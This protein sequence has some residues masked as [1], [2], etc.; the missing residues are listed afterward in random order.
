[1]VRLPAGRS[2]SGRAVAPDGRVARIR[3]H[4]HDGD[5]AGD[6]RLRGRK[7]VEFVVHAWRVPGLGAEVL[8]HRPV[9]PGGRVAAWQDQPLPLEV[10]EAHGVAPRES[11]A[12]R[13]HHV[14]VIEEQAAALQVC[15]LGHGYAGM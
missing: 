13:D 9:A 4:G 3:P 14:E 2:T 5:P 11:V 15:G 12:L 8:H 6:E 7:V 10:C 1:M